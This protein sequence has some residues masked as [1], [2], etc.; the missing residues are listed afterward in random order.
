MGK[1]LMGLLLVVTLFMSGCTGLNT[2]VVVNVVTDGSFVYYI[3]THPDSKLA[4]VDALQKTKVLLAKT[5]TYDDL[6]LQLSTLFESKYAYIYLIIK[7]YIDTDKPLFETWFPMLESYK[8]AIIK[9]IDRLLLLV[10]IG[11]VK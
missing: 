2:G 10:D 11:L 6:M 5:V 3:Q 1:Y 9:K 7:D 4:V 8:A